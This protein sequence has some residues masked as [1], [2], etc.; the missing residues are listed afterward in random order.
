MNWK[1]LKGVGKI[2]LPPKVKSFLGLGQR[3][4]KIISGESMVKEALAKNRKIGLLI[5]AQDTSS[6]NKDE[7]LFLAQKNKV[8]VEQIGTK[9]ELGEAIGK[10]E[11]AIIA[12]I[13]N[14]FVRSLEE[15]IQQEIN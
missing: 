10:G 9:S 6:R 5:V 15:A 13:D 8:K 7:F 11:R 2:L 3:A 12:I 14:N 1:R 4:G